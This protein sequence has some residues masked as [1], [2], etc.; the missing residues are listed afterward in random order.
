[1]LPI[2]VIMLHV[3]MNK[4]HVNIIILHVGGRKKTPAHDSRFAAEINYKLLVRC[5]NTKLLSIQV[6][7]GTWLMGV[8]F[9]ESKYP[10]TCIYGTVSFFF[11]ENAQ[12]RTS[13]YYISLFSAF[14]P[15]LS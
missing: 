11:S 6:I 13:H 5:R 7:C 14:H 1:M 10:S 15:V 4:L 8:T 2:Y 12:L 3:N 9:F